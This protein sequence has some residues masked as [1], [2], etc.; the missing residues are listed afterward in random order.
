MLQYTAL[1]SN[2]L[3]SSLVVLKD[4]FRKFL[5]WIYREGNWFLFILLCLSCTLIRQANRIFEQMQASALF[6]VHPPWENI[7]TSSF[8]GI[9]FALIAASNSIYLNME[10]QSEMRR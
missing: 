2:P 4:L 7:P 5:D 1:L 6:S 8:W 9:E 10:I 3:R